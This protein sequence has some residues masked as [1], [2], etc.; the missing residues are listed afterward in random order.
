MLALGERE[1][2]SRRDSP[3]SSAGERR[4]TMLERQSRL[5]R[6]LLCSAAYP[7][8]RGGTGTRSALPRGAALP[9]PSAWGSGGVPGPRLYPLGRAGPNRAYRGPSRRSR[10][11]RS[12]CLSPTKRGC[13][14]R[15]ARQRGATADPA[16]PAQGP[17]GRSPGRQR[18]IKAGGEGAKQPPPSHAAGAGKRVPRWPIWPSLTP[19][20]PR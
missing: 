6:A 14:S 15:P 18:A 7:A 19:V 4:S 12:C 17:A 2:A 1:S 9:S 5:D 16:A 10:R 11:H 8:P 13:H 20:R 3:G